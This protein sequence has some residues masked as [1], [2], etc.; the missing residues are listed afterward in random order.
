MLLAHK[1]Q[2]AD[3]Q[4]QDTQAIL[5]AIQRNNTELDKDNWSSQ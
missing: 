2:Q 4:Q 1:Y 5:E 3:Y